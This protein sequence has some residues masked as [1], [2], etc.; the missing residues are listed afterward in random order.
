MG[1]IHMVKMNCREQDQYVVNP[2]IASQADCVFHW[3]STGGAVSNFYINNNTEFVQAANIYRQWRL[4]G[5]SAKISIID[6]VTGAFAS[7]LYNTIKGSSTTSGFSTALNDAKIWECADY[8]DYGKAKA[9]KLNYKTIG[10]AKGKGINWLNTSNSSTG[11]QYYPDASTIVRTY[12]QGYGSGAQV[13]LVDITW[14]VQ[15]K[16]LVLI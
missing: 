2:L 3:G 12:L 16:D 6:D 14:H 8:K 11:F 7:G 15:F 10:N 4:I 5:F 13:G 9:V 1:D